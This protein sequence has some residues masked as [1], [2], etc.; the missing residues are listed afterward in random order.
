MNNL[1]KLQEEL[2]QAAIDGTLREKLL[3][4]Q[5]DVEVN[6]LYLAVEDDNLEDVQTILNSAEAAGLLKELLLDK[7]ID[8]NTALNMAL[9]EDKKE[10]V[11]AIFEKLLTR[12]NLPILKEALLVN[13]DYDIPPLSNLVRVEVGLFNNVIAT[14][15]AQDVLNELLSLRAGESTLL[16]MAKEEE[17][18]DVVERISQASP[19]VVENS[20]YYSIMNF[21]IVG[22]PLISLGLLTNRVLS[23]IN[24]ENVDSSFSG[25]EA[26]DF[27][28]HF[29]Y[30]MG[31]GT[32]APPAYNFINCFQYELSKHYEHIVTYATAVLGYVVFFIMPGSSQG[33]TKKKKYH[34]LQMIQK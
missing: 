29:G 1:N 24:P 26:I 11:M 5:R 21:I 12:S 3:G 4:H 23:K 10:I 9:V 19:A 14:A 2:N 25:Q 18:T 27:Y 13:N 22:I 33:S 32:S 17:A 20:S 6:L 8:G 30:V 34:L 7:G 15:K 31:V 28:K 16:D